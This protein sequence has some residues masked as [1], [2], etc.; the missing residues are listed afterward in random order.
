[1]KQLRLFA[2]VCLLCLYFAYATP[3]AFSQTEK[4]E[5]T[6][7]QHDPEELKKADGQAQPSQPIELQKPE[8]QLKQPELQKTEE[9]QPKPE[10]LQRIPTQRPRS[11]IPGAGTRST[12]T[13]S[14]VS[15]FFDD[16]NLNDVVQTI[17]GEILKVNYIIDPK[18]QGRVNFRTTTPIPNA[19]VM[20]VVEIILRINGATVV[21][22][23]GIY[24]IIPI[25]T[26]PKEP[27]TINFG[28]L[29]QD[30]DV[31]GKAI[32]QIVPIQFA[33]STEIVQ[34][35][36]PFL[37]QGAVVQDIQRK[38]SLIIADTDVNIKKMLKIVEEFDKD[39]DQIQVYTYPLQSI[40]TEVAMKM[41]TPLFLSAGKTGKPL[42]TP[43]TN[44]FADE[45]S[46]SIIILATPRDYRFIDETMKKIDLIPAQVLIEA[47][48]AEV[49][50]HG[51]FKFGV[52]WFLKTKFTVRGSDVPGVLSG[53]GANPLPMAQKAA[54]P[55]GLTFAALDAGGNVR[56][57]LE[58]LESRTK[59]KVISSPNILAT[60]NKEA[61]I[62]IGTQVPIVTS[63]LTTTAFTT[64]TTTTGTTGTVAPIQRTIQYKDTGNILKVKPQIKDGG[65]VT[66]EVSTE[67]ST[68]KTGST[69]GLDTTTIDKT[70][71][72]TTLIAA[73]NQTIIMGGFIQD[74]NNKTRKGI[75]LL[76]R[77]PLIGYLFGR[78]EDTDDRKELIVLL[79][80]HIIRNKLAM[81]TIT[82]DFIN[83]LNQLQKAYELK[84]SP[85]PKS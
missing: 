59:V 18:V 72:S 53:I 1:M 26:I 12:P 36:T 63:D 22:D 3:N 66:L 71:V 5:P 54:S 43:G 82:E 28:R 35:L 4:T 2:A 51:E 85:M 9:Q 48:I 84:K 55:G 31:K 29:P 58:A 19:D 68:A 21:E 17:F 76:S 39:T 65:L 75:P 16:A 74:S 80:P 15:F 20:F 27:T 57:L 47:V 83:K 24:K 37:S 40:T 81:D 44:M 10:D 52:D 73:D 13:S 14:G 70:E 64:G 49:T 8:E 77:I 6:P 56:G 62:L 69:G 23:K 33:S 78:T 45:N 42:V 79:T 46:N 34:I 50:M 7:E 61:K 67:V 32:V 30:V 38:N 25:G 41:I 11:R 60:N